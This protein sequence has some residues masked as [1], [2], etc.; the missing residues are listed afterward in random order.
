LTRLSED[1][2]NDPQRFA[3]CAAR[4]STLAGDRWQH[5]YPLPRTRCRISEQAGQPDRL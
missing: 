3:E 1:D 2:L 5:V 4:S